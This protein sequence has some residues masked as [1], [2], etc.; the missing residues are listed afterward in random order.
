V[1]VQFAEC[2][3][4]CLVCTATLARD[5]RATYPLSYF[6]LMQDCC[7]RVCV[8]CSGCHP[9]LLLDSPPQSLILLVRPV[10]ASVVKQTN[11]IMCILYWHRLERQPVITTVHI[12]RVS[13]LS[14]FSKLNALICFSG[15]LDSATAIL[16]GHKLV[17][18]STVLCRFVSM[19][20]LIHPKAQ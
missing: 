13:F 16:P 3:H 14:F 19:H 8:S 2:R 11:F 18:C 1:L 10:H 17:I 12:E 20:H 7:E 4:H 6:V 15:W 5:I 9:V